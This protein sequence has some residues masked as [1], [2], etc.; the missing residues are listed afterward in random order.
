MYMLY[1][2][3]GSL[4]GKTVEGTDNSVFVPDDMW[5]AIAADIT[6]FKYDEITNSV[7]LRTD[8]EIPVETDTKSIERLTQLFTDT[9]YVE[10]LDI[11]L[12]FSGEFGA[13][14]CAALACAPYANP[15]IIGRRDNALISLS[16]NEGDAHSIA[17]AYATKVR[18]V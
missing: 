3:D 5:P 12:S 11:E 1:Q 9:F 14:L 13:M 17:R 18:K 15:T 6:A 7:Q 10:D 16:I 2:A 8:Y 4:V